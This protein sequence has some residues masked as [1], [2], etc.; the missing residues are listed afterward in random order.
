M[1]WH[2]AHSSIFLYVTLNYILLVS[3]DKSRISQNVL[4][5]KIEMG[6]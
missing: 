2:A 4:L 6:S 1:I 3:K 5:L